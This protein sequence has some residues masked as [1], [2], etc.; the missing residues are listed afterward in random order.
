MQGTWVQALA[1]EDP[2]EKGPATHSYS[3]LENPMD[4]GAWQAMV[5]RVTESGTWLKQ[6]SAQAHVI[7]RTDL[8]D[9]VNE[10]PA[11]LSISLFRVLSQIS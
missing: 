11:P 2:L 8:Q 3:C 6:L 1:W 7:D 10:S 5:H 9:G 4:R